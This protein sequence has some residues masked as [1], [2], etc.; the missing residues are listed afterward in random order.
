M[1]TVERKEWFQDKESFRVIDVRKSTNAFLKGLLQ[2][3]QTLEV[4]KG[5]CVIQT[6]NPKPL[7]GA[8]EALGY[9][10]E[11]EKVSQEEY[12][13]YFWRTSQGE[14]EMGTA[15]RMP[16]KPTAILNYKNI[17]NTLASIAVDFW[18]LTWEKENAA[19]D[20]KTKLMLSMTNAMGAGRHRQATR[21]IIKAYSLGLTVPEMDEI[22][23][24]IAW[25]QGIGTFSSEFGPSPEFK[26]YQFIKNK[27]KKGL[28]VAQ[29]MKEV[30]QNFGDSNPEVNVKN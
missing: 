1:H 11:G 8:M 17:D 10:A 4:G 7:Y 5:L 16:F 14:K 20:L 9:E 15:G 24:L 19:I 6:F 30:M 25:N 21:E 12:R 28:P 2:T 26:V 22:F 23:E 3:A 18:Q 13:A 27:E 29:I